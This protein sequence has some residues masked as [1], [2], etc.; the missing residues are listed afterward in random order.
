M[1]TNDWQKWSNM[2]ELNKTVVY[3]VFKTESMF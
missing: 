2:V 1:T 3:W